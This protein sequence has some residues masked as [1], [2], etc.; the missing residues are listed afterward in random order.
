MCYEE[1]ACP[2]CSSL[3][4]KKNG[5]TA[6]QKQRYRCKDCE[7]QFISDYTY[8]AYK[9]EVR[10]LVLPMTMNGSGIRD[11]SR[12][13]RISTNTVLRLIRKAAKRVNE[14]V[15]PKRIADLELDEFW[16]FVEKKKQQ[17]WTWYA[18]D[19]KLK[20]VTAFVNGR[21]TDHTCAA[22]LKKL[23]ASQVNR[24]H[25]DRWES[26]LKLLPENNHVV[27]KEGTRNIERHNL[28]FRTHVKR[29]QRRTICFSKSVEMH[30]AVIKLYVQHSNQPQHH[31]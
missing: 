16:S 20:Q 13:L 28:N 14:P 9:A 31:F 21:R 6:Q 23:A 27:G 22:L 2:R 11:I 12:V 7:R 15:V 5:I 24:F 17:R 4:V 8:Q 29:L 30:D 26:Y 25:T 3:N 18:F 19:R 10:S 1:V